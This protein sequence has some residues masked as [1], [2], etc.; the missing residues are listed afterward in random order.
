MRFNGV[1]AL[2]RTFLGALA[3]A[4]ASPPA[5]AA[6]G[7]AREPVTIGYLPVFRGI[8]TVR[9]G[10]NFSHYSHLMLAFIN[11]DSDGRVAGGETL[12]CAPSG[13]QMLTAAQ[14]RKTVSEAHAAGS[15]VLASVGGGV[16]PACSGDWAL[17]LRP[18]TRGNV[19]AN[20]VRMVEDHELDGIDV[21]IEGEL[22]TRIDKAGNYTPFIA[23]LSSALKA[24]GKL[25]TCATAS[26]EG[27]MV[28]ISSVP[29][30]DLVGV[31][32]YD[33]IGPSWGQAGNEHSTFEQAERDLR[34]WLARGV[35]P[36]R[37]VLGVPFYGY[38]F[39]SGYR[40]SYSFREIRDEFGRKASRRDLIGERCA[41]CAYI[42]YNGLETL[43]KKARLVR[44]LGAG[45]MVWEIT[46]DTPDALLIRTLKRAWKN[47]GR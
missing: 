38:G 32:S 17:L 13:D 1:P 27:G 15:K 28:P 37:L 3:I 47:G 10:A 12:A 45:I 2:L 42:T 25:L 33:A 31:M 26:Y 24:R 21:D 30:F 35:A 44:Q 5:D 14:L 29:Y 34:L 46:Q 11:P 22:L 19:I 18:E 9:A 6:R 40:P 20:L 41:G 16:I 8:E 4:L 23:E 39:G 43:K 7:A 36:D